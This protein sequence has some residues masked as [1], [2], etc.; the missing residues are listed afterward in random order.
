M[1]KGGQYSF[2]IKGAPKRTKQLCLGPYFRA[3]KYTSLQLSTMHRMLLKYLAQVIYI[4]YLKCK[5]LGMV[6][7][8]ISKI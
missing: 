5:Y 8:K 4:I 7:S 6:K 2:E 3:E 1:G